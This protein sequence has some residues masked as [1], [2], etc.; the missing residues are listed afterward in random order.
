M[1]R[2]GCR[3]PLAFTN[4]FGTVVS[5]TTRWKVTNRLGLDETFDDRIEAME[6]AARIGWGARV[7]PV[8]PVATDA[9]I[10]LLPGEVV[11]AAK[12]AY[13][14]MYREHIGALA[15]RAGYLSL[16]R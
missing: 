15:V 11:E 4:Q 8:L 5:M 10:A 13:G 14:A 7:T 12:R 16:V 3:F 2:G 9:A 1:S 6:R